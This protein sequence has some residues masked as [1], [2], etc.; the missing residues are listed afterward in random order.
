MRFLF[1][2]LLLTSA[3]FS[4]TNTY[5]ISF[6]NAGHH[7]ANVKV[8]FPDLEQDSLRVRMSRTSPGRYALHEFAKNVYGVKA[9]NSK[10]EKLEIIRPDP[11][12]WTITDHDGTINLE[13][14]L[15][16]NRA[17]GTYTQIDETHAHLNIPA[18]FMYSEALKNDL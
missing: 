4:Q 15:F 1:L 10:G 18:T 5:T 9:T 13:Y 14:T 12:S 6:E 17:D 2:F 11:Y 3:G 7:E 16:G 8:N